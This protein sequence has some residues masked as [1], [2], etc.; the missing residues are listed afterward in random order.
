[1]QR[2]DFRITAFRLNAS[3]YIDVLN[4]IYDAPELHQLSNISLGALNIG[5]QPISGAVAIKGRENGGNVLGMA[6]EPQSWL[7]LNTGWLRKEDDETTYAVSR[8]IAARIEE[9]T[10][11][12][13]TFLKYQFMND[14][15]WDQP[16][17]ERYGEGNVGFLKEV[18]ERYDAGDVFQEL[19]TGGW[20]LPK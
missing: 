2:W 15:S 6:P 17:I 16:V 18:H 19:V 3:N 1:M 9:V 14:A 4:T 5:W 10:K 7:S 8:A 20:K 13:G 12:A 11:R